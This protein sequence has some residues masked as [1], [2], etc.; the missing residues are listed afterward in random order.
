[1]SL[2]PPRHQLKTRLIASFAERPEV[3]QIHLFGR[4]VEGKADR[5][6]DIDIILC[7][8]DLAPTQRAYRQAL[9]RVSPIRA[10][11]LIVSTP[12]QLSEMI[13]LAGY[14]PYQKIDLTIV[15]RIEQQAA[16]G[17]FA[18]AY[19]RQVESLASPSRLAV[20][21]IANPTAHRLD[22]MLFSVPRFTKCLFRGDPDMYRRWKGITDATLALLYEKKSGW[23]TDL[24]RVRLGAGD[25]KKLYAQLDASEEAHLARIYPPNARLDL[26]LSYRASTEL[27]IA[28]SQQ[29]ASA[30]GVDLD[31]AFARYVTAFMDAEIARFG[32]ES[33]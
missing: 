31:L 21:S 11:W 7:S 26:A 9:E 23:R 24:E 27:F 10:V 1:M 29:K 6:S 13:M 19:H 22:E 14:S 20:R 33:Q 18:L 30:L 8:S 5:Y 2:Q 15:E 12:D 17:P 28:L 32:G 16:F 4:E 3:Y 25:A